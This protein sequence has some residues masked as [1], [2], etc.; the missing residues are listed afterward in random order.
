MPFT[1][2]HLGLGAAVKPALGRR[3]SF[4]VFVFSQFLI[5]LEPAARMLLDKEPLHP[6]LH[7][8]AGA[9][10][11][12]L[13]SGSLGRPVCEH[14]LRWWNRQLSATQARWL[15]VGS[16]IS[17]P[18]AWTGALVGAY[19]HIVLDSIMHADVHPWAPLANGNALLGVI[20]IEELHLLCT[21]FG[22]AGVAALLVLRWRRPS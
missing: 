19:S 2:F 1:P 21:V 10:L 7:T 22:V 6:H 15:A 13:I 14:A 16:S 3:F 9:T 17:P 20:S 12:A 5:D 4:A 8:F 18:A 11:V